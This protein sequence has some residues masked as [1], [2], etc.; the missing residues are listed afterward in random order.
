MNYE[1]A[2]APRVVAVV[3]LLA[4]FQDSVAAHLAS[5]SEVRSAWVH[6]V[7]VTR[8]LQGDREWDWLA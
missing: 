2:V 7:G 1:A 6:A 8:C 4:F 3:T 5:R